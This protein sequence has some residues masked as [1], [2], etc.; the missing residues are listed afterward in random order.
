M[1]YSVIYSKQAF[2]D[3]EKLPKLLARRID[4]KLEF[5]SLQ[6]NPLQFAKHLTNADFGKYRF[7]IGD[8]RVIFD[9]DQDGTITV[10]FILSIK[11]RREVYKF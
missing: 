2:H 10:L 11:H 5:F 7:R 9:L 4:K 8:Y 6:N 3:L 1:H